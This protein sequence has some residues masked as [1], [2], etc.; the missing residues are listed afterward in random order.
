MAS[1]SAHAPV[2]AAVD[3]AQSDLGFLRLD[4]VAWA[5]VEAISIDY[6]IMEKVADL[7]V[8]PFDGGWSDLGD[9]QAVWREDTRDDGGVAVSGPAHAVDCTNTLL[10]SEDPRQE[11]VGIGLD[12]ILAVAMPDAVLVA[13]LNRAQDVRAAVDLLRDRG[14]AQA[15]TFPKEH[16]PWGWIERLVRGGRF[17]VHRLVVHPG[18]QL[19][20]QSH[21]HR[22]EHWIVV[23]GTARVTLEDK[24]QLVSENQSIYVPLGARHR[25]ENP[26]R[27]PMVLIEVQ[28]G[29]YLSEDDV[30]RYEDLYARE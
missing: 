1:T 29:G 27:M 11:I 25:L 16:R 6:A 13:D 30:T 14:A 12:N 19:S 28:T 17:Q 24:V 4:P 10:R 22:S 26:G 3:Q 18:A 21:H 20:L 23:E 9:W 8:V 15:E 5:E 7:R 2:E